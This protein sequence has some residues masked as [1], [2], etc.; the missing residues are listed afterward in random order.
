MLAQIRS[1]ASSLQA[2][3]SGLE[4]LEEILQAP[5]LS[6]EELDAWQ[7]KLVATLKELL[8]IQD[9]LTKKLQT[10]NDE[11]TQVI[12]TAKHRQAEEEDRNDTQ[13]AIEKIKQN[14][15]P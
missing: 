10:I 8:I 12:Q 1:T 11:I 4:S 14:L 5:D 2:D 15:N 3:V 7:T 9:D 13:K 6:Q